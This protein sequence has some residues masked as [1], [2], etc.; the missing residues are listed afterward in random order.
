METQA[1][2]DFNA[3][4]EDE[5]SFRKG[6]ILKILSKEDQWYKAELHGSEGFIPQ[7]Y[8]ALKTPSWFHENIS[9]R[10]AE[11]VLMGKLVGC[12]LVRGS[13]SSPGDFSVSVRHEEDVQH[14]KVMTDGKGHYFLWTE[15]FTSLNKLV[16][17]YKTNSIAKQK[18]MFLL[19]D[20]QPEAVNAHGYQDKKGS[21]E[22]QPPEL[23]RSGRQFKETNNFPS[24]RR[25]MESAPQQEKRGSLER[26]PAEL[27]RQG[28][29][30]TPPFRKP[31]DLHHQKVQKVRALYDFKPEEDDEL[32][33]TCDDI[34][35]VLDSSDQLWWKGRFRGQ[36]GL[37]PANYVTPINR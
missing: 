8:V 20:S 28:N 5:L 33:F 12:F 19:D 37:F 31:T 2:Y 23:P 29:S 30:N 11:D 34:I 3:N 1:K 7:N 17:Y 35:E 18:S 4:G 16:E 10:E 21:L 9:R 24:Y 22:R 6:D 13:Q 15:K 26:P 14:F 27:P 36:V 32:G 25:P